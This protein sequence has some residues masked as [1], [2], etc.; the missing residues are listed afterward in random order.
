LNNLK[1]FIFQ[2]LSYLQSLFIVASWMAKQTENLLLSGLQNLLLWKCQQWNEQPIRK[3]PHLKKEG[4]QQCEKW[5]N[6]WTI[7]VFKIGLEWQISKCRNCFTTFCNL[8]LYKL[9]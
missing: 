5:E 7:R 2:F 9:T 1:H 3:K 4:Q 6:L 8:P